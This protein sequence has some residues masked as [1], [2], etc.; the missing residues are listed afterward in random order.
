MSWHDHVWTAIDE[1]NRH[2]EANDEDSLLKQ[3]RIGITDNYTSLCDDMN[4]KTS[5]YD[6]IIKAMVNCCKQMR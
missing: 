6:P 5:K 2:T 4:T 1:I 3:T